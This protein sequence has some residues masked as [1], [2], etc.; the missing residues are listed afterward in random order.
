MRERVRNKR[1]CQKS[2]KGS[3]SHRPFNRIRGARHELAENV[4]RFQTTRFASKRPSQG[5]SAR[6]NESARVIF[7]NDHVHGAPRVMAM[8][9]QTT[10]RAAVVFASER[11]RLFTRAL[12][13][14]FPRLRNQR[15]PLRNFV[16]R[17]R[18]R[19]VAIFRPTLPGIDERLVIGA[20][21]AS[22]SNDKSRRCER[23]VSDIDV[24]SRIDKL[25][26]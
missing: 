15:R 11:R 22:R 10:T 3:C 25:A 24:V 4:H 26:S 19:R 6:S 20:S 9:A 17:K 5:F 7:C 12:R 23:T 21:V 13:N 14:F 8:R 16:T 2:R 1:T 18:N